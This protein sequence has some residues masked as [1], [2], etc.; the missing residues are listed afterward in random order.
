M[1]VEL[2]FN[3]RLRG[4]DAATASTTIDELESIDGTQ[5]ST[6]GTYSVNF[7]RYQWPDGDQESELHAAVTLTD[8][9]DADYPDVKDDLAAK[10]A[11]LTA[12]FGTESEIESEL[13]GNVS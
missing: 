5:S 3:D 7:V 6:S 13:S 12:D 2:H 9:D 1:T 10:M 4:I 8:A 11:G